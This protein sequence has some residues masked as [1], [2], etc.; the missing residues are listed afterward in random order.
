MAP[1]KRTAF[2]ASVLSVLF[3]VSGAAP[4][5][6]ASTYGIEYY[7][8]PPF[9][10]G[11]YL[12][13][14]VLFENFDSLTDGDCPSSIGVG[15][16]SGSRCNIE[17]SGD[18]GGAGVV[19]NVSTPTVAGSA[20]GKYASTDSRA[21]TI[22]FNTDQSYL[23]LWWSA[24]SAGNTITFFD[25]ATQVLALGT[26]ELRAL[27]GA[28][29]ASGGSDWQ[30]TGSLN[31]VGGTSYFKHHFFGNPRGYSTTSPTNHSSIV[32]WEPFVYIHIFTSGGLTFDSVV[33][34]GTDGFEFDNIAVSSQPQTPS[35]SLVRIGSVVSSVA[36][37]ST[38]T[39][40]PTPSTT[41]PTLATTGANVEWIMVTG[42]L[43]F[44]A[45]AGFLTV[46]RRKRTA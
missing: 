16:V 23:G 6:H 10:Q 27:L 20:Q 34:S 11:T 40:T 9:T 19:A 35:S 37:P 32:R 15:T 41:T 46:S 42:L 8:A 28:E 3:G 17:A 24:G 2:L 12:S 1:N 26:A 43:A 33:L 39:P 30:S 7:I 22:T 31:S 13:S 38:P 21:M 36:P 25:G 4:V 45:G 44:I 29:P 5:A 14:G 18:F